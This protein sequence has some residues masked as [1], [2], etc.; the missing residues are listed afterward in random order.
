MCIHN[1][2]C[3]VGAS[4][5]NSDLR[6][7]Q[8]AEEDENTEHELA[9]LMAW[10]EAMEMTF[11]SEVK[12]KAYRLYSQTVAGLDEELQRDLAS[13]WSGYT[14]AVNKVRPSLPTLRE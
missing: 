9:V 1:S 2:N 5:R 7:L 8:R 13:K 4:I 11:E 10:N 6:Y 14:S 3:T 12:L